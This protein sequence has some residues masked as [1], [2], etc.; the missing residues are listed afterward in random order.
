M[1]RA[2]ITAVGTGIG[3]DGDGAFDASKARYHKIILMTDADVDG[4]HIMTLLLTFLYRQMKGLIESGYVY[5][6]QPPL[7]KIK[8]K[9]R[10]QYVDNDP[11]LN[12]ILLELGS[13]DV[14]LVRLR[15]QKD[16]SGAQIDEIVECLSRL[17][18][19]GRGVTRYGC[20]FATYLDEHV[21]GSYELPRYIV[22]IRTGN[23]EEFRFL[24]DDDDR[25]AFHTE[26]ELGDEGNDD[27]A[28]REHMTD[29]ELQASSESRS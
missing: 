2:L 1:S 16:L 9:R 11:Q 6:A 26:F 5:I 17:E 22:R 29:D 20:D 23:E 21:E 7:Y 14:N 10:E 19:L 3:D 27:T 13:E 25:I 15:D 8:R 12:R 4:A 28:V 24:K 18:T